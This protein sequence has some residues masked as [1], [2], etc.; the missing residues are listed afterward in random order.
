MSDDCGSLVTS[1][2][3]LIE[4]EFGRRD[5]LMILKILWEWTFWN[6]G[7]DPELRD[8]VEPAP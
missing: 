3:A 7:V 4:R 6:V 2:Q 5:E 1:L 8:G